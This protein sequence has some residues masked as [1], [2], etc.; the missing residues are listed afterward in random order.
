MTIYSDK[1][2]R[3][4]F[5]HMNWCSLSIMCF[6]MPKSTYH[7]ATFNYIITTW[8]FVRK[9]VVYLAC[10]SLKAINLNLGC[11]YK[12]KSLQGNV[13]KF[14]LCFIIFWMK[15]NTFIIVKVANFI[16]NRDQWLWTNDFNHFN[17]PLIVMKHSLGIVSHYTIL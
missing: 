13:T 6:I 17:M 15:L 11:I 5:K 9:F 7:V 10:V 4:G 3:I 8:K 14:I 1:I 16:V 2:S 12:M